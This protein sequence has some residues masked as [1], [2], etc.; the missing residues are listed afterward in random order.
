MGDPESPDFLERNERMD[1]VDGRHKQK[2]QLAKVT[3]NLE[4]HAQEFRNPTSVNL[5][6][7]LKL[8]YTGNSQMAKRVN[9]QS[10]YRVFGTRQRERG[11][12]EV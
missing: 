7:C 4:C 3:W 12:R 2:H 5:H 10:P 8:F 1:K 11:I 9:N 6:T